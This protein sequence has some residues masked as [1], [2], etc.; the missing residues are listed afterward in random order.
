M[1]GEIQRQVLDDDPTLQ[2]IVRRLADAY[3]PLQIYLFGS[4]ARG[5]AGPDSDYD[6]LVVMSDD[7]PPELRN[8]ELAYQSL[9]GVRKS[10][11]VLV[12]TEGW[13]RSR[14]TVI[15][16]LPATVIRE[17]KLLYAA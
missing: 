4:K 3:H 10:K 2:E 17:G 11:D 9:W 13:F 15:T 5:T 8:S 12:C 16:S 14:A 7:A 6:L 1:D